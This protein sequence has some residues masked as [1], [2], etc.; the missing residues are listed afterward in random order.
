MNNG[1]CSEI[2]ECIIISLPIGLI[3]TQK[4]PDDLIHLKKL[5]ATDLKFTHL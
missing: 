5:L 1:H 2:K 4:Q 3:Q